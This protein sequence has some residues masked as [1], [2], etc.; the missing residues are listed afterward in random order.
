M[1][2]LVVAHGL[3][4]AFIRHVHTSRSYVPARCGK[5]EYRLREG[6]QIH[7]DGEGPLRAYDHVETVFAQDG[8]KS[9][10][11]A[12]SVKV[13]RFGHFSLKLI[14]PAWPRRAAP[15]RCVWARASRHATVMCRHAI[16]HFLGA[17]PHLF[18]KN[19]L[20]WGR[21]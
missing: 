15:E 8:L 2:H 7:G 9:D 4:D 11:T 1:P 13:C 5:D 14:S 21:H 20:R 6:G 16:I 12:Q 18:I 3:T 10:T 17:F 19:G